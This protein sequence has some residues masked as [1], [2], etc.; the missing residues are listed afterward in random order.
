MMTV[1]EWFD[2]DVVT[3]VLVCLAWYLMGLS[4][5]SEASSYMRDGVIMTLSRAVIAFGCLFV[6]T[7]AHG[8]LSPLFASA[9]LVLLLGIAMSW[10]AF[11]F[12]ALFKP[13]LNGAF[14]TTK[15]KYQ[16]WLE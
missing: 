11:I 4:I 9:V 10:T 15:N 14:R 6:A 2:H 12:Y 13:M 5:L 3:H 7:S 1:I 8:H 16:H